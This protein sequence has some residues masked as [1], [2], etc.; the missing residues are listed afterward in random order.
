ML[1]V[2]EINHA[3]LYQQP[4]SQAV[5][6]SKRLLY[7]MLC[8]VYGVY[9]LGA[10]QEEVTKLRKQIVLEYQRISKLE[11]SEFAV[12]KREQE[13]IRKTEVLRAELQK[14]EGSTEDK[15]RLACAIIDITLGTKH[16]YESLKK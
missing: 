2:Q 3:A 7:D 11:Q 12:H 9:R 1:T 15:L 16:L 6:S 10:D 5:S 13:Q 8:A 14:C 4:L